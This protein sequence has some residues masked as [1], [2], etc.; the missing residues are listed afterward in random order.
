MMADAIRSPHELDARVSVLDLVE[1]WEAARQRSFIARH[2]DHAD[3]TIEDW[4]TRLAEEITSGR[5][6]VIA[7]LLRRGEVESWAQVGSALDMSETDARDGFARWIAGQV[8]LWHR[9]NN[10][11]GVSD[12]DSEQ[13]RALSAAITW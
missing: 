3:P 1:M 13:L 6:C 4:W 8:N 2:V 12:E 10:T 9:S 5:W 7:D 11:I